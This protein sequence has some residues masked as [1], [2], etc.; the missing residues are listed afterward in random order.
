MVLK[1]K[2]NKSFFARHE[3]E[4]LGYLIIR[5][6]IKPLTKK[7]QE[8]VNIAAPTT[9][10][11]LHSFI[12]IVNFYYNIWR[13]RSRILSPLILLTSKTAI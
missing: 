1:V 7:V 6:F 10:K 3:V 4:Y 2:I 13:T 5:D 9:K 11:N 12:G 8:I